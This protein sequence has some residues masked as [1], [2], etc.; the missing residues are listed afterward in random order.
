MKKYLFI[1]LLFF[2]SIGHADTYPAKY[3]FT[4]SVV[5][6]YR[7]N[8]GTVSGSY[9]ADESRQPICDAIN[10]LAKQPQYG[11]KA[12]G[13]GAT[14]TTIMCTANGGDA[15]GTNGLDYFVIS[16][17]GSGYCPNGGTLSGTDCINVTACASGQTR[18]ASPP[19]QCVNNTPTCFLPQILVNNACYSPD[20]CAWPETDI[21]NGCA[22]ND[23]PAGQVRHPTT[24][25]CQT[26]P[27][28]G[29]TERYEIY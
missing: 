12:I 21:G 3:D 8:A 23:C 10:A 14:A 15:S 26:T 22:E 1:L 9:Y 18:N 29:A 17:T 7:F 2:S 13:Y 19:H 5:D 6:N 4:K 28:C 16:K 11:N 24:N 25:V 20:E 27:A